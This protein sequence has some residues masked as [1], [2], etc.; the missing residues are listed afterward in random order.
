MKEEIKKNVRMRVW[1]SV[2][3]VYFRA[4]MQEASQDLHIFGWIK[5]NSDGTVEI[6]A[7]GEPGDVDKFVD[8]VREGS[9][10]SVV[11]RIRQNEG[12]VKDYEIFQIK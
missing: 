2:Q 6:E 1:G 12:T 4:A 10:M 11:K 7:E 9:D 5:N 8:R 3:G